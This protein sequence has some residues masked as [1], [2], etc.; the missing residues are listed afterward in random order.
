MIDRLHVVHR[1]PLST[2]PTTPSPP[3]LESLEYI[4]FTDASG[5]WGCAALYGDTWFQVKWDSPS[6]SLSITEKEMINYLGMPSMGIFLQVVCH[7]DN[8]S[9]IAD[10]VQD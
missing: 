4:Y 7:S 2:S 6:Q 3:A 9:V 1:P 5:S 10:V 8:Q